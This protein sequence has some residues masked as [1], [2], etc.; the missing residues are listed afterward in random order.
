MREAKEAN[1]G[2]RGQAESLAQPMLAQQAHLVLRQTQ[3]IVPAALQYVW[4]HPFHEHFWPKS[5]Q[6]SDSIGSA[7][8]LVLA[9]Y[10]VGGLEC[11]DAWGHPI[12]R[13][14]FYP[15]PSLVCDTIVNICH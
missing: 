11:M 5:W 9:Q 13:P 10:P 15:R 2:S 12:A 7:W 4:G 6:D 1:Y 3:P 14:I 8:P